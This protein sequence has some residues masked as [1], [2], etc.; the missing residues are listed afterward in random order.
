[1]VHDTVD[2]HGLEPHDMLGV[3]PG[4]L[5]N[6]SPELRQK[7]A[8]GNLREVLSNVPKLV[9]VNVGEEVSEAS[10]QES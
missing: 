8:W 10:V 1:M 2:A 5:S 7:Q 4:A 3:E 6:G 9:V